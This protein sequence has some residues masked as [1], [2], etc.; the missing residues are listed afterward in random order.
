MIVALGTSTPTSITVVATRT[1]SSPALEGVH[2]LAPVGRPQLPVQDA[3]P[4]AGE[5]AASETLR[6]LLRRPGLDRLRLGDERADDVRLPAVLEVPAEA[7]VGGAAP[8]VPDPARDHGL[9]VSRRPGDLGDVE[10]AEDGLCE[11]ARDRRGGHVQDVRRRPA[12]RPP[13]LDAE[14]VL[15]VDDGDREGAELDLLLDERVRAHRK[16]G[17]PARQA[18]ADARVAARPGRSWSGAR[19]GRRARCRSPRP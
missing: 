11:R 10:I 17:L 8:L 5:L 3:D 13:L 14:T 12:E 2:D 15:L 6:L 19:S 1:S 9:A 4:K 16:I 18:V 7:G